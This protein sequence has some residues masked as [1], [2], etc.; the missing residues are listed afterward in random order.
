MR[1]VFATPHV[2]AKIMLCS[3]TNNFGRSV[4]LLYVKRKKMIEAKYY[5]NAK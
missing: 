2:F 1:Y 3:K 5:N 4:I